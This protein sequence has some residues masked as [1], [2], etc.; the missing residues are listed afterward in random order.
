LNSKPQ[1]LKVSKDRPCPI[2]QHTDWCRISPDG[3]VA[4][5]GRLE[6]GSFQRANGNGGWLH[7][8][9]DSPK[10]GSNGSGRSAPAHRARANA[11]GAKKA[12]PLYPRPEAAIAAAGK[13][14]GGSFVS[15][16]TYRHP[17][18]TEALRVVRFALAGGDKAYRPVHPAEGGWR[19]GDPS[20]PLPLYRVNELP[21]DGMIW[22]FE[23]EKAAE[24]ARAIGLAAT[25]SAHGSAA[26]DKSDWTPLAGRQVC[27]LPDAD[28]AGRKYAQAVA[29]K[30]AKLDPPAQVKIVEL[31]GLPP[32][33]DV[34]EFIESRDGR[35]SDE[36]RGE[37]ITLA[38]AAKLIDPSS[39]VGGI[40]TRCLADVE[41]E[42]IEWVWPGRF[43]LGKLSLI[44]GVPGVGKSFLT[45]YIAAAVTRGWKWPDGR[46]EAP[47]GDVLIANAEDGAADTIKPRLEAMGADLRRVHVLDG[48]MRLGS[49][50]KLAERGF[51]LA[52]VRD[53]GDELKRRP[54]IRM[55][56]IDPVS[57]F[58]ADA[59]EHRNG[60][61]RALLKPLARLAERYGVAI[62]LV[63]HLS[64]SGGANSVH[65]MI[66]SV[67]FAGAVRSVWMVAKDSQNPTRRLL[68][69]AKSNIAAD[70]GGL[71]Y[72]IINGVVVWEP[73]P[74]LMSADDALAVENGNGSES[75]KPGPQPQAR[76]AAEDWLAG[77]LAG[78]AVEVVK[79][80]AE[81]ADAGMGWRTVHR[82]GDE[83][84]V[85]REKNEFNGGWQ[86]RLPRPGT[87]QDVCVPSSR[88]KSLEREQPGILAPSHPAIKNEGFDLPLSEHAKIEEPGTQATN[89]REQGEV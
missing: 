36:L 37:I 71:A 57:A 22:V 83:L 66:G 79:L 29:M 51:T 67:A 55:V 61:V 84:G 21:A 73:E 1:W 77:V 38:D 31:P 87:G 85:I 8:L 60:E 45:L 24:A 28:E 52:D 16:W 68:L 9:A 74:V 49:D 78:G 6:Q 11:S 50:G 33:G 27:I 80:K 18:G 43:A 12:P 88:D 89:G 86:W 63:T 17:D 32:G 26:T 47:P 35:S 58:L 7:H 41:T 62:I 44:G 15:A 4:L 42:E 81:A 46:G 56:V 3:A 39:L 69:L 10:P 76:Q 19:I 34:V 70:E 65:R 25:T 14:A 64:K 48:I 20:G 75:A 13:Q 5:C 53:L 30:A 54:G 72:S 23:G 82:A 40:V 59:D 2:C